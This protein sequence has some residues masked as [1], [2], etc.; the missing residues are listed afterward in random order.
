MI[1]KSKLGFLTS[2]AVFSAVIAFSYNNKIKG[3]PKSLRSAD[4]AAEAPLELGFYDGARRLSTIDEMDKET[5]EYMRQRIMTAVKHTWP[6][7][8]NAKPQQLTAVECKEYIDSVSWLC[9]SRVHVIHIMC[10]YHHAGGLYRFRTLFEPCNLI[11]SVSL[12]NRSL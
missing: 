10:D 6:H 2:L 11:I 4:S 3:A 5:K 9:S 1:I 7:C 12:Y 8:V